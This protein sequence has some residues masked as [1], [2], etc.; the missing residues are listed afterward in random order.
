MVLPDWL[1]LSQDWWYSQID[2]YSPTI[3]STPRFTGTLPG[4]VILPDWLVLSQNRWYS[5]I[6]WYSPRIGG[7]PRLTGTLPEWVVFPDLVVLNG[8][9]SST[10]WYSW[11]GLY[12]LISWHTANTA[13]IHPLTDWYPWYLSL[14]H[15]WYLPFPWY[16][17]SLAGINA[18]DVPGMYQAWI[19]KLVE[20]NPYAS[21]RISSTLVP[22]PILVSGEILACSEVP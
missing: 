22:K 14:T 10:G 20:Q 7:T 21:Y 13:G 18:L 6:G 17:P 11:T 19:I 16:R 1:V 5:Q 4:S 2:W 9:Y 15:S 12:S 8:C 3:G